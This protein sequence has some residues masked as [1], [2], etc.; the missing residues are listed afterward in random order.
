[1]CV[2][3]QIYVLY[4]GRRIKNIGVENTFLE[5]IKQHNQYILMDPKNSMCG[6]GGR[7]GCPFKAGSKNINKYPKTKL[8]HL[9]I[10]KDPHA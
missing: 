10:N 4:N 3:V 8:N 5:E 7:V 2:C 6:K 1:M 9:I